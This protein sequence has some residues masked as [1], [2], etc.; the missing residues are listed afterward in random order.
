M[1]LAVQFLLLI[2]WLKNGHYDH[3]SVSSS[4]Y[5]IKYS[6]EIKLPISYFCTV[7]AT[8]KSSVVSLYFIVSWEIMLF[9]PDSEGTKSGTPSTTIHK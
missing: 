9:L 3:D 8:E 4:S 6:I 7:C 2:G 1:P 5:N